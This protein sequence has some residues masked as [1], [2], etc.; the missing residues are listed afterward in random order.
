MTVPAIVQLSRIGPTDLEPGTAGRLG[1]PDLYAGA[2]LVGHVQHWLMVIARSE[3]T[4]KM[5][6]DSLKT[7]IV[8]PDLVADAQGRVVHA[9]E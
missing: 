2:G 1:R 9:I 8:A 6:A 5:Q 4:F 7:G 3:A